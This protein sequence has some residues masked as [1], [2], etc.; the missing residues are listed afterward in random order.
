MKSKE[1]AV[2]FSLKA[3]VGFMSLLCLGFLSAPAEAQINATSCSQTAVQTAVNS[4]TDGQTISVP[5][6]NCTWATRVAWTNKNIRIQGA[7][8]DQTVITKTGGTDIFDVAMTV[9]NKAGWRIDDM[10]LTGNDT[11]GFVINISSSGYAGV[12]SG[13]RLDHLKFNFGSGGERT[14][15]YIK[16]ANYGVLDHNQY[17]WGAGA[18]VLIASIVDALNECYPSTLPPAG[19]LLASQPLSMGTANAVY[20]EDSTIT[21]TGNGPIAAYDTSSG[22]GRFVFRHNTLTGG[23]IYAHWTRG[24]EVGGILTE[25][26]N[27]T[28]VG[29]ADWGAPA[30]GYFARLEAGTGVVFN[31]T[32]QN[33]T[34]APYVILDDRRADPHDVDE[35]ANINVFGQCAG[36]S[37][38]DGNL[39][40]P[41]APGWP[42]YGQ[43][44]RAPGK[45]YLQITGGSKQTSA[46]FYLWNNG[47]QSG[48]S[49]GGTCTNVTAVFGTPAA[50]VKSTPHPNGDVDFCVNATQPAGCGTATLTYAPYAYPHPLTTGGSVPPPPP[51]APANPRI[52]P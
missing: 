27:N 36:A 14:G 10:T 15:T 28:F 18:V 8:I 46:P 34:N 32:A 11:G 38:Y 49:N 35:A 43:P 19:N 16:G 5:A 47:L 4:A 39:G 3:R 22:G 12:T 44:G 33:F 26:Y 41:A 42:C 29:N 6:G 24:C 21:S 9:A 48:C 7:G 1:I 2:M 23:Y 31:N 25:I 20:M 45:S 40:D 17:S 52:I 51:L 37:A 30:A 13:W 50:Y